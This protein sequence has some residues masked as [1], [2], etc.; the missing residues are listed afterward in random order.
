MSPNRITAISTTGDVSDELDGL[1]DDDLIDEPPPGYTEQQ[2]RELCC[3]ACYG[4]TEHEHDCGLPADEA[5]KRHERRRAIRDGMV[6]ELIET[7]KAW[8]APDGT[9][10]E[11]EQAWRKAQSEERGS[12]R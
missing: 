11:T 3:C 7:G 12:A 1:D 10:W 6:K 2:W 5:Q 4:C 9:V 8:P